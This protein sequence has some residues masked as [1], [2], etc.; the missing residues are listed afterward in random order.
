MAKQ[1][2]QAVV[3]LK[4]PHIQ[5]KI[6]DYVTVSIGVASSS[7]SSDFENYILIL[8]YLIKWI[9]FCISL[10]IMGETK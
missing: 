8:S 6:S 1:I 9:K 7:K 3:A 5:S 4:I 10:R 2:L